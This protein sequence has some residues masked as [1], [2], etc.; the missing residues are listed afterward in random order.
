MSLMIKELKSL[1]AGTE[2]KGL[3]LTIKTGRKSFAGPDGDWWQE[4]VFFDS[5]GEMTGHIL[6]ESQA[7]L[8]QSKT[9][10]CIL[11]AEIQDTDERR[12][13]GVKLVVTECFDTAPNLSYDQKQEL[14]T[15]DWKKLREDEI[16]GKVRHGLTCA[17]I[18]GYTR[19]SGVLP[20]AGVNRKKDILE[21]QDF[22]ITG[23]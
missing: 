9:I 17:Y 6:I 3:S 15:E 18:E 16:K 5:S 19:L 14:Y 8:W 4:V 11:A 12:K 20:E 22:I 21:W 13:E 23:E 7:S 10:L 1:A 2:I